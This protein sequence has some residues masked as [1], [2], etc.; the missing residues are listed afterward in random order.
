MPE[1]IVETS[2]STAEEQTVEQ[3]LEKANTR[4]AELENQSE[5][6]KLATADIDTMRLAEQASQAESNRLQQALADTV[7]GYRTLVTSQRPEIPAELIQGNSIEEIT[8]SLEKANAIVEHVKQHFPIPPS[9]VNGDKGA[10]AVTAP[11]VPPGAPGRAS[12]DT[13]GLPA[14]EKIKFGVANP[15]V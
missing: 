14:I 5:S 4:I 3:K 2:K 6:L 1:E 11:A 10:D 13:A 9:G 12:P 7:S 15:T 8:A